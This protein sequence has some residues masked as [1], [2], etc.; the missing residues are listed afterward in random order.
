MGCHSAATRGNKVSKSLKP[1]SVVTFAQM[2]QPAS[3]RTRVFGAA[4]H[5]W[6]RLQSHHT[7]RSYP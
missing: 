2:G 6:P 5:S 7:L 3:M 1:V 4:C